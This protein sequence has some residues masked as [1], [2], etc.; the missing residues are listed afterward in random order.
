MVGEKKNDFLRLVKSLFSIKRPIS[1]IF[2]FLIPV[3][4]PRDAD[5]CPL[6]NLSSPILETYKS[7]SSSPLYIDTHML[8]SKFPTLCL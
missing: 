5:H 7:L 3:V 1:R 6:S 2:Y 8:N 4:P